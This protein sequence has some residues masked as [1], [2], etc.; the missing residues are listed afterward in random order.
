MMESIYRNMGLK[1]EWRF[2]MFG[3]FVSD[4]KD[5][6]DARDGMQRGILSETLKYLALRGMS[7]WDDLSV[8]RLIYE[9]GVLDMR[10]PLITSMSGQAGQGLPPQAPG[11]PTKDIDTALEDGGEAQESDL[12]GGQ[13]LE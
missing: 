4:A 7:I 10:I 8:S 9:S 1:H 13:A 6:Q 5:L 3:G 11:R 2:T 12:D